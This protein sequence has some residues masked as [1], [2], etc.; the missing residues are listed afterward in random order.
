[1]S[2]SVELCRNFRKAY[3]GHYGQAQVEL[4]GSLPSVRE[5]PPPLFRTL[6]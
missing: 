2:L 5:D 1:M 4:L 3:T 6:S